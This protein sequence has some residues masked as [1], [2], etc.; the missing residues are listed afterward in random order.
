MNIELKFPENLTDG[1]LAT[2]EEIAKKASVK[3]S[4]VFKPEYNGCYYTTD[5]TFGVVLGACWLDDCAD[6]AR[7][8]MGNCFETCGEAK[9]AIEK[10]KVLTEL[11]RYAL[12][13]NKGEIDWENLKQ[14]KYSIVLLGRH[15][16]DICSLTAFETNSF[17]DIGQ[18][19]FTSK[20]IAENA[21][22]EIGAERIKKYLFGA[23]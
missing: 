20:E 1:E 15:S 7:Y 21:I 5:M 8:M 22:K 4:K 17:A 14:M 13:H 18:I 3:K 6:M 2:I 11:K 23:K 16:P 9:F 10:Q 19:Y 12:E